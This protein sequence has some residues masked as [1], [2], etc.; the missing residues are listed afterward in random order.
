[1][2]SIEPR[3]G[4]LEVLNG[5]ASWR[6]A[7]GRDEVSGAHV[8]PAAGHGFAPEEI[9]ASEAMKRLLKELSQ[10]YDL[11]ILDCAP[12]LTLAEVRDLAAQADGVIVVARRNK[13]PKLALQTA[14]TELRSI[15]ASVLG[16]VFN[17]ADLGAPGRSSY[18]DPLYFRAAKK[19]MYTA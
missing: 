7:A 10:H 17:G 14:M 13:T 4:V 16:V 11:V 2:L 3:A 8:L 18:A 12:I 1:M 5:D 15:N 9:F 19:E 6:S